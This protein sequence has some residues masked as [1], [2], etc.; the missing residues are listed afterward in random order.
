MTRQAALAFAA[1]SLLLA[2]CGEGAKDAGA[3]IEGRPA[4]WEIAGADGKVEGWMLGTIHALPDD[5]DWRTDLL[6]QRLASAD[7][8]VVEVAGLDDGANLSQLFEDMAFDRPERPII[9]RIDPALHDEFEK[10]LVKAKV[11]RDYFDPMESWAAALALAQVAQVAKSENGVDRALLEEFGDREVVELEGA[12]AQLAIFDG[13]PTSEQ[14]D[15]LNAVLE[16]TSDFE[17]EI[18]KLARSWQ[19]GDLEELGKLTSRGIL[20]DPQLK[21]AL[22]IERNRAWSAQIENL[23]STPARPFVAVG[24]GHLLGPEGLPG[25][26]AERGYTVRRIQ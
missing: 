5:L 24:A 2:S 1:L 4:V 6:D 16:E 11:R 10:L 7:M 26:L 18:G 13:L 14:R 12:E 20:G 8:L 22:L 23:L 21:R 17:Q 9:E 19:A 25:L 15:L 3:S